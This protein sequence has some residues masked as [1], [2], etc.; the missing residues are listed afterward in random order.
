[1][2]LI[3]YIN[4]YILNYLIFFSKYRNDNLRYKSVFCV[5]N[6][7]ITVFFSRTILWLTCNKF[8]KIKSY[9]DLMINLM[10]VSVRMRSYIYQC[11]YQSMPFLIRRSITR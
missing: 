11:Y 10:A 8:H 5:I 7:I 3:D 4:V 1:M 6:I 9:F 2:M